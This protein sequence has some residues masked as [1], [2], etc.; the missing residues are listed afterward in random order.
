LCFWCAS[1][2]NI[3]KLSIVHCP[4]CYSKDVEQAPISDL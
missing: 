1:Y 2:F 4:N 3:G